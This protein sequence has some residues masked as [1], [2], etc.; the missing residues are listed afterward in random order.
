[1]RRFEKIFFA[2]A[3]IVTALC[4]FSCKGGTFGVR[5]EVRGDAAAVVK[6]VGESAKVTVTDYYDGVP[7]TEVA[8]KAFLDEFIESITLP[9]T[10]TRI[11]ESGFQDCKS[12]TEVN[13][14][15]GLITIDK[16]AFAGCASLK[17]I[18][19]PEGLQQSAKT[20]SLAASRLNR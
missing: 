10:I 12:L 20:P 15:P 8:D 11:G 18:V 17:S 1:M 4:L 3:L 19:L 13:L 14:S 9:N 7:V 2:A 5:I 6:Y 16:N